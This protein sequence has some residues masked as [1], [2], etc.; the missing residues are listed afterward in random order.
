MHSTA[1]ARDTLTVEGQ[2]D[3]APGAGAAWRVTRRSWVELP[4]PVE[5]RG[6]SSGARNLAKEAVVSG[7]VG[8]RRTASRAR[9]RAWENPWPVTQ[10][11]G[12]HGAAWSYGAPVS[13]PGWLQSRRDVLRSQIWPPSRSS[14]RP[15]R[16]GTPRGP[17]VFASIRRCSLA[18]ARRVIGA[19][20]DGADFHSMD[21]L[22]NVKGESPRSLQSAASMISNT[23]V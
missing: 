12:T 11:R 10:A 19:T 9:W 18:E 17:T 21:L 2:R 1:A 6:C 15:I 5:R 14:C 22:A 23:L 7:P 16:H 4:S 8:R 3:S 20:E 13:R